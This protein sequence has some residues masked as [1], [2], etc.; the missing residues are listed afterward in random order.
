MLKVLWLP[1]SA[2]IALGVVLDMRRLRIN[3]VGLPPAGWFLACL[4]AGPLAGAIYLILRRSARRK[5]INA[6]WQIVGDGSHPAH[7]RR[8]RLLALERTGLVGT[9]ILRVCL[10]ALD[11]A[12]P[13]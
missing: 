4:C 13:P 3:R 1:I 6:V 8:A 9:A 5:L 7:V 11:V 12:D 10:K 2:G